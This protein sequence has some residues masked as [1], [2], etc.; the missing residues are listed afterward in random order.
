MIDWRSV[1]LIGFFLPVAAY[2][3]S[4]I[5]ERHDFSSNTLNVSEVR[6]AD[7]AAS[8]EVQ[9][10]YC[11]A[12]KVRFQVVPNVDGRIS[13]VREAVDVA[14]AIAGINGGYFQSD[15]QPDGLL[16]SGGTIAHPIV[17][18]RLLSGVFLQKR[19]R[20][21]LKRVQE[22][23]SVKG[24]E[25]AIQCGPFLVDNRRAVPGLNQD[26]V[27]ARTFVFTCASEIWGV[28][29]CRSVTLAD[30]SRILSDLKLIPGHPIFRALNFD[31]GSSTALY[32]RLQ[33]KALFS[34]ERPIVGNYLV[35][36]A[37][38]DFD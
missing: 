7:G 19:G 37:V 4:T 12:N 27:A 33:S 26:R 36:R 18:G 9:L 17:H 11:S 35:L 20:P 8:A 22:L 13:G 14:R 23:T 5:S 25:E 15:L 1:A 28:G 16:I 34:E 3:D 10:V 24:L 30:L 38:V 31:G 21:E 2:A 6:L 32:V 29:I